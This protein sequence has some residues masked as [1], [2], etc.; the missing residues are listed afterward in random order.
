MAIFA[1]P[2]GLG[3]V[4]GLA[5]RVIEVLPIFPTY[6]SSLTSA[7]VGAGY[8]E[9]YTLYAILGSGGVV[10]ILLCLFMSVTS[11][12][13]SSM[14]AVSSILSFDIYRTYI[15][16]RATDSQVVRASHLGV[17]FHGV[18]I[19]GI[20]LALNYGG[21]NMTWVNYAS[22]IITSAAVFPIFFTL[23]WAGQTRLAAIVAPI[24]GLGTGIAIWLASAYSIY[25]SVSLATTVELAPSLYGAMGSLFS[26]ILYSVMISYAKPEKFDWRQFLKVESLVEEDLSSQTDVLSGQSTPVL[27][28]SPDIAEKIGDKTPI[29]FVNRSQVSPSQSLDDL[30][31]PFDERTLISLRRWLKVAWAVFICIFAIT[32]VLWPLPLYRD[33]IFSKAFFSGWIVVS[34][35]WQFLA[36]FA[37]VIYPIYDGRHEISKSFRGIWKSLKKGASKA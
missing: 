26:P 28:T 11:T 24:L 18:F 29:T 10:G 13:S 1:V 33:Y 23:M 21:A 17:V 35:F 31:H 7:Q 36:L 6:P 20:A 25:G 19:A 16:P 5:T 34:I 22:P 30:E 12:V 14:I 32:V 3:T 4:F 9:P 2:W 15:N 27:T 37:V 8:V